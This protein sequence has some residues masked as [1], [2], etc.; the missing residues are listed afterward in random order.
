MTTKLPLPIEF[1]LPD[2]WFGAPP[3]EVGAPGVAFVAVHQG[4]GHQGAGHQGSGG[5]FTPNITVDGD[6][7]P[8]GATL[9]ETADASVERMRTVA[10]SVALVER[11][12]GG[13]DEVRTLRQQLSFTVTV[14]GERYALLQTQIYLFLADDRDHARHAVVRLALTAEVAGHDD[15]LAD[16]Y[17]VVRSVAPA[18][19]PGPGGAEPPVRKVDE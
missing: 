11:V 8:E 16:F 13:D 19:P 3:D 1:R 9:E 4:A 10:S 15:L 12:E 7:P 17:D 5:G 6:I 2:G 18:L 14:D